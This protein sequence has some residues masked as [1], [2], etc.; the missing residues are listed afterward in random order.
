M[1][2]FENTV[3]TTEGRQGLI[4]KPVISIGNQ[5]FGSMQGW[6]L[7]R[8]CLISMRNLIF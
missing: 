7:Y 5:D 6:E 4:M 3:I 1:H 8:F 2:K